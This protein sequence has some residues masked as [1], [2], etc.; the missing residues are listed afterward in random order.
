V[1]EAPTDERVGTDR[2]SLNHRPHL[3]S[4]SNAGLL[5]EVEIPRIRGDEILHNVA[6]SPGF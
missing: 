4:K 5:W 1:N 3:D 2:P 6:P